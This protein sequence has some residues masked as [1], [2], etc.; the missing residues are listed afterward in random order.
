MS[1]KRNTNVDYEEDLSQ[2][3]V[4]RRNKK[5]K[6][7]ERRNQRRAKRAKLFGFESLRRYSD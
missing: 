5:L 7:L 6:S 2:E 4:R 1:N 3:V